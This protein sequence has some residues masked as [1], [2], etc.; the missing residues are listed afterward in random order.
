M[1]LA[2]ASVLLITA[3]LTGLGGVASVALTATLWLIALYRKDS[4]RLVSRAALASRGRGPVMLAAGLIVLAAAVLLRWPIAA[5]DVEHYA[6]PD[7]GEVVENVL[8]MLRMGDYDHRHPGYPGL[9]FYLQMLPARAHL[10]TTG[11]TIPELPRADFYLGARRMTLVAGALTAV[12]VLWAGYGWLSPLGAILAAVLVAMSPLAFRESAV[13]NPDLMLGLF[14]VV[15]LGAS[16]HV[17]ESR[18]WL[19]FGV[20]GV[21]VGLASAIKYTGG[22]TLLPLTV[23][24]LASASARR[25]ATKWCASIALSA[26]CFVLVSPYTVL[27]VPAFLRGLSMHVGYYQAAE[28][29]AALELTRQIASRGVGVVAALAALFAGVRALSGVDKRLLVLLS[30]PLTYWAVFSMFDRAF[31]RHALVLIP[32]VALLAAVAFDWVAGLAPKWGRVVLL[33]P[34]VLG[35]ALGAFDLHQRA[36]RET[37]ADA[38]RAWVVTNLP[39]DSRILQ[40]QH[41]PRLDR[42]GYSVDRIRVEERRFVGNYDWVLRSGYPPGLRTDG[43]REVARFDN[44]DA[45]GDRIIAYQVPEREALM[46]PTFPRNRRRAT[47]RAGMLPYFGRGWYPP[48]SGAFETSRLSRG[49]TS[50]IFFVLAEPGVVTATL[51]LGN[52]VDDGTLTLRLN[53]DVVGEL[54]HDAERQVFD[55]TLNAHA[56]LN[57]L[58]LSYSET[59]RLNRRHQDVAVRFY[60]LELSK[61]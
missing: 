5:H 30:Y 49:D 13:V 37:P 39:R 15:S 19:A 51:T 43:L 60:R 53:A 29:N 26:V 48:S 40:D 55:V 21:T 7:E 44:D 20:A 34:F 18:T 61:E 59:K 58:T 32:F 4:P 42:D 36:R 6:G 46:P 24:W 56:G 9:H 52:A 50:E 11:L 54:T 1:L 57:E 35:P 2:L 22:L 3:L 10:A 47:I 38:A 16:L 41:T 12:A 23:A 28:L 25:D 17:L 27:N 31:P 14:V 45:L 8:E 33:V